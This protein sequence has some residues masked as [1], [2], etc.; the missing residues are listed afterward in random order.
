MAENVKKNVNYIGR[1]FSALRENIQTYIKSYFGDTYKDFTEASPG[2]MLMEIPA[3]VGDVLAFYQDSMFNE[4]FEPKQRKNA[5]NRAKLNGYKSTAA[6]SSTT[7]ED[8]FL[9]VPATGSVGSK[10]PDLNYCPLIS[11]GLQISTKNPSIIFETQEDINFSILETELNSDNFEVVIFAT[12]GSDVP[13]HFLIK[14]SVRVLSGESKSF[15]QTVGNPQKYLKIQLP[16]E[17]I[18][19]VISVVDS[20]D[21][22]WYQVDSLAQ[23]TVFIDQQNSE[24]NDPELS[25]YS[26]SVPYLL[27]LKKV[28]KRFEVVL[29]ENNLTYLL[30]GAGT[31]TS[32]D[33][34]IIPNPSNVGSPFANVD[35]KYDYAV[36]PENFLRTN[37]FGEAP[38]NTILTI[39]YRDGGGLKTNVASKTITE[40]G[41]ATYSFPVNESTLDSKKITDVKNSIKATNPSMALGGRSEES[42][43]TI[44]YNSKASL[45]AQKRCVT[46]EDYIVRTY[47]LPPKFGSIAKVYIEKDDLTRQFESDDVS[48]KAGLVPTSK[49][50][51]AMN[52]FVLG[53]DSSKNLVSCPLALKRNI[54]TYLSQYRM[55]TDTI[56]IV[57]GTVVNFKIY[58]ELIAKKEENKK[59][60]LMRAISALKTYF[61]IDN[62]SFNQPIVYSEVYRVLNDV[63]G[64]QSVPNVDIVNASGGDYSSKSV[65]FKSLTQRG[66]IYPTRDVSIFEIKFPN[67]DIIGS[68]S[69]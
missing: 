26:G 52:L 62:W 15:T 31:T 11:S 47:L 46:K 67:Q 33:E 49:N 64:V 56:N 25:A 44:S 6:V 59:Q 42:I 22:K 63:A 57:D 30:F 34:E 24:A 54:K 37:T 69:G 41:N 60:V 4:I 16:S 66:I 21:N 10:T 43:N 1:D 12:D 50:P 23:D 65:D 58:F 9:V 19:E 68:V 40:V 39:T 5:L 48:T 2:E 13:T 17:T 35:N 18:S 27:K 8:V 61:N 51:L 32:N 45:N 36:D 38:A 53:Y 20:N 7:M 29:D 3:Y 28:P 55:T 14:K